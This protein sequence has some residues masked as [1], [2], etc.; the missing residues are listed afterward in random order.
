VSKVPV[1]VGLDHHQDSI[2]V[3][4]LDREGN[5]LL[6]R[7]AGNDCREVG[8]IVLPLWLRGLHHVL[9]DPTNKEA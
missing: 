6:N 3:C 9:K 8:R 7:S 4:V 1:F 5:M 2:Q